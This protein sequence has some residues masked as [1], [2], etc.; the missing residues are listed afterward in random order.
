MAKK[1]QRETKDIIEVLQDLIQDPRN[2]GILKEIVKLGIQNIMEL[3]RDAH[4]GAVSYERT[5]SR[6]TYRNGNK[7][8][9]FR[10][11][12]SSSFNGIRSKRQIGRGKLILQ[13]NCCTTC[14]LSWKR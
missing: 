4:I 5:G 12:S 11:A 7:P 3:E 14:F 1:E 13:K 2:P 10:G 8:R 9:Q 6:K